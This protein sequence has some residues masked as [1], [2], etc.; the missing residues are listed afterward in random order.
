MQIRIER[1]EKAIQEFEY[2]FDY[3]ANALARPH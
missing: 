2:L 1:P 3:Y